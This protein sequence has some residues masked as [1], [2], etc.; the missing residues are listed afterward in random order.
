MDLDPTTLG[1][2]Y[3]HLIMSETGWKRFPASQSE[4]A[5][6]NRMDNINCTLRAFAVDG[7]STQEVYGRP[8]KLLRST[9]KSMQAI[10]ARDKW[11][12]ACWFHLNATCYAAYLC[13]SRKAALTD[14]HFVE[15]LW[16]CWSGS[17]A[18]F[19]GITAGRRLV[20]VSDLMDSYATI[21][22]S[23]IIVCAS[24]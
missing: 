8:E 6:I 2:A 1:D 14:A 20:D 21:G 16:K 19:N 7:R 13:K 22:K 15:E 4:A 17:W 3:I 10:G 12:H 9:F 5:H 23:T 24:V 11:K 18:G